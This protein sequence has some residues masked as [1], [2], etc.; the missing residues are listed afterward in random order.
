MITVKNKRP[1]IVGIFILLGIAILVVTIFTLG[2]QKKTFV[3]SFTIHAIFNDVAGLNKGGNVWLSGVKVGTVKDIRFFGNS[4]VD[5]TLSIEKSVQSHIRKNARAKIGSDGLIGNRIVIIYDGDSTMLP[6]EKDDLLQVEKSSSMDDMLAVLQ[7]SSKNL[8]EITSD[9]KSISKK[10]NSGQGLL[11]A[12]INDPAMANKLN[13][14]MDK[15]QATVSNFK[16]V[17][18]TGKNVLSDLKNVSGKL[19]EPGNSI[20]DLVSDTIMYREIKTTLEQLEKSA[21][22]VAALTSNLNAASEKLNKADNAAGV[23]LNDT[24]TAASIKVIIKNLE[25]S[26]KKLDEDLRA[27]QDNFLFRG[28]FKKQEKAKKQ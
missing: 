28:Y 19:N 17:S 18:V 23:I 13:T 21:D 2:G 1:V 14:T 15:L 6:V 5:V 12:L 24:A 26:S 9:F 10:I 20:N 7:S 22:A 27:L 8:F 3:K 11:S 25:T 16:T 4:Q